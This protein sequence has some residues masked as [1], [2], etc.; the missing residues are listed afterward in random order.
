MVPKNIIMM[1]LLSC[2]QYIVQNIIMLTVLSSLQYSTKYYYAVCAQ[3]SLIQYKIFLCWQCSA[4]FNTVKNSFQCT[5]GIQWFKLCDFVIFPKKLFMQQLNLF[6]I[7]IIILL[8]C[9]LISYY[10]INLWVVIFIT[11]FILHGNW[12]T[13]VE[14]FKSQTQDGFWKCF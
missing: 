2:L 14:K 10:K 6:Y 5:C 7:N 12:A 1:S 11:L 4:I 9:E 8:C 13:K 3:L